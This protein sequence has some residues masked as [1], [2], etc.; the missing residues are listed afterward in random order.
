M[1]QKY[2]KKIS[3]NL[4]FNKPPNIAVL[5]NN[6]TKFP[7]ICE[8]SQ[9]C[10]SSCPHLNKV[11]FLGFMKPCLISFGHRVET[12]QSEAGKFEEI[13]IEKIVLDDLVFSLSSSVLLHG[14]DFCESNKHLRCSSLGEF[15]DCFCLQF[16]SIKISV[17]LFQSELNNSK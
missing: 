9:C 1:S 2:W 3:V 4:V 5:C 8:L 14:K 6:S 13:S 12:T 7:R 16:L 15:S 17:L 10:Y 11:S